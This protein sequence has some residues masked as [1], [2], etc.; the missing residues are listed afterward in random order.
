MNNLLQN[1]NYLLSAYKPE[2]WPD[3][4]GAEVAFVGR[5][6]VGKSSAINRLTG[7]KSLARTSKTPGRTQQIIFFTLDDKMRLVD[8]PGYGYAKVPLSIKKQWQQHIE[9]YFSERLSLKGLVLPVDIRHDLTPL[10]E[11]MLVYCQDRAL[12]TLILLTKADKLTRNHANRALF[13][14]QKQL[15]QAGWSDL[16]YQLVLFSA[17]SG[18]G[19]EQAREI[20][21]QWLGL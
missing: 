20:V 16:D 19:E 12:P 2:H 5:S 17:V 7:Q 8:L 21:C 13:K 11:Q 3:D 15:K 18:Q 4:K 14:L 6:N 9:A 1:C 10:D